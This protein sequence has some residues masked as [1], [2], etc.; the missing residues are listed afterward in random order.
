M[1]ARCALGRPYEPRG[2]PF[3][4]FGQRAGGSGLGVWG[5]SGG[6]LC[7]ARRG[8]KRLGRRP[9]ALQEKPSAD[10][11]SAGTADA[12]HAA[13]VAAIFNAAGE[14]R[15]SGRR[16]DDAPSDRRG[17]AAGE[18]EEADEIAKRRR[19]RSIRI[20]IPAAAYDAICSTLPEYAPLWP[21]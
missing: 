4:D 7:G 10:A 6:R 13:C 20:A 5:P 2:R 18:L 9:A 15:A 12:R 19:K 11:V 16:H 14:G 8:G 1:L 17:A 3:A 21:V